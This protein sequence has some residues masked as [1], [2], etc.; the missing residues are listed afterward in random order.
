MQEP[1]PELV[2]D[3]ACK[4]SSKN[5]YHLR[6]GRYFSER[7]VPS[8]RRYGTKFPFVLEEQNEPDGVI[9]GSRAPRLS[10]PVT[11]TQI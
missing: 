4:H 3:F 11:F 9:D 1:P 7:N 2:I 6:D 10:I 5:H 8:H